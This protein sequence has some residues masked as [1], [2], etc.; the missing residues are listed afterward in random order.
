M[1]VTLCPQVAI[2]SALIAKTPMDKG[3]EVMYEGMRAKY[4]P[5]F[6]SLA[7]TQLHMIAVLV[8]EGMEMRVC[9]EI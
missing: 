8:S 6:Y 1:R 3:V 7:S 4:K 5:T 9:E 2:R